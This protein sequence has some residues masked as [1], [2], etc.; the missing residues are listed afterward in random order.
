MRR[1][2][3]GLLLAFLAIAP[4][5]AFELTRGLIG[6][7]GTLDPQKV[8]LQLE[9]QL[10]SD[11][12]EPLLAVEPDGRLV[13]ALAQRWEVSADGLS[14]IFHLRPGARWSDGKPL[15][16]ADLV[17][18][19][20]RLVDPRTAAS[21]AYALKPVRNA[22]A[23][24]AGT[25]PPDALDVTALDEATLRVV[26]ER[27]AAQFPAMVAQASTAPVRADTLADGVLPKLP[28]R[29]VSNGAYRLAELSPQSHLTLERNPHHP[30]RTG[31][32]RVT[33]RIVESQETQLKLFRAGEVGMTDR[34]PTGKLDWIAANLPGAL[35]EAPLYSTHFLHFNMRREPWASNRA[36]RA[37]L[38]MALDR[39]TLGARIARGRPA[40]TIVP[41]AGPLGY[42]PARPTWADL[43][44]AE[45]EAE[46]RR[47]LVEAGYGP[48][49]PPPVVPVL[50]P[51]TE[52]DRRL[53]V[54]VAAMWEQVLG[55]KS[56]LVGQERRTAVA[57]ALEGT[58]PGVVLL[59]WTGDYPDPYTFLEVFRRDAG[60]QNVSGFRD[61]GYDAAL[62]R[63]NAILDQ[64]ERARALAAA[65]A[66][67]R[68]ASAML[69]LYH[70][71]HRL[72]VAPDLT[73][74]RPGFTDLFP[75]RSI[76]RGP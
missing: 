16:A 19:W 39:E 67:L 12:S 53:V 27:P 9:L 5:R 33:Y 7:P 28:G 42:V 51:S 2:V 71:S 55:V 22:A 52:D 66:T 4:A 18:S 11:L 29:H 58:Y 46:A 54:A 64:A 6:E 56:E 49:K 41:P 69:P 36:L 74:W 38:D 21:Y 73:G 35:R 72:L 50:F 14:Y 1:L 63:A 8:G 26:L 13:P 75:S 70:M 43:P 40:L 57:A 17:F 62:D 10:M 44:R 65:E 15:T 37:A 60:R 59:A 23:I 34:A 20:R 45:R 30:G 47:L 24:T 3:T 32:E 68:D 61:A 25:M 48:G 31:P 76:G